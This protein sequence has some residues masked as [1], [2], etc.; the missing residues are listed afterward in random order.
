VDDTS[1]AS[2]MVK[3]YEELGKP[4]V[5]KAEALRKAQLKLLH[6]EDNEMGINTRHPYY[7]SPFILVGNW[8]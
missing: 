5:N 3:F 8:Q 6:N 2:L 4:D 1:T 7:W